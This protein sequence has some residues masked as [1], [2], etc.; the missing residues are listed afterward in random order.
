MVVEALHGRISK[1]ITG[2]PGSVLFVVST[3]P[4]VKGNTPREPEREPLGRFVVFTGQVPVRIVAN[5]VCSSN[6]FL[7]PS[8]Q[9]DGC[10][11]PVTSEE[12][13]EQPALKEQIIGVAWPSIATDASDQVH[14]II[15]P[16]FIAG[17]P[18]GTHGNS[19]EERVE[20]LMLQVKQW[21]AIDTGRAHFNL[22]PYQG[23]C[24][25][26]RATQHTRLTFCRLHIYRGMCRDDQA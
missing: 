7:I 6:A 5:S 3:E 23:I 14:A 26:C 22:H 2:V 13:R 11:R 8:G 10:A 18:H 15:K 1:R 25:V 24:L 20:R 19:T 12:L 21:L 9:D 17:S 16:A 4:A